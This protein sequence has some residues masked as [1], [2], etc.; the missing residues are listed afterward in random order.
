MRTGSPEAK[1]IA[2]GSGEQLYLYLRAQGIDY[3]FVNEY[4][5]LRTI[6]DIT[7]ERYLAHH[8]PRIAPPDELRDRIRQPQAGPLLLLNEQLYP[9]YLFEKDFLSNV[10]WGDSADECDGHLR[11][12]CAASRW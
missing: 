12:C 3:L 8:L 2:A 7:P 5:L 9:P 6:R 1:K 4:E 11:G 10:G